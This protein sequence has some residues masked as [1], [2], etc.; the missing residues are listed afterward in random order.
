MCDGE[1]ADANIKKE[2][3]KDKINIMPN[4]VVDD[5]YITINNEYGNIIDE[6]L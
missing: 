3:I 5:V 4:G 6:K 2:Y 1:W